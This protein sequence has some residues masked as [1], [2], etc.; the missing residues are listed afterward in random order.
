MLKVWL[1]L[2]VFWAWAW[3]GLYLL[4]LIVRTAFVQ[5]PG[6]ASVL[7]NLVKT[8]DDQTWQEGGTALS[9]IT[10]SL[11]LLKMYFKKLQCPPLD[12]MDL[13]QWLAMTA[14]ILGQSWWEWIRL[15]T[16]ELIL[17]PHSRKPDILLVE[18]QK[19][20]DEVF[21]PKK[22]SEADLIKPPG[23]ATSS[24]YQFITNIGNKSTS[25]L[26]IWKYNQQNPECGKL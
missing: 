25:Q 18:V 24:S 11:W 17:G 20:I 7:T 2:F 19:N 16:P 10:P 3:P 23:L 13:E 21:M 4:F 12:V 26:I 15:T 6:Q 14:K 8:C 1:V 5:C 22:L 9:Y